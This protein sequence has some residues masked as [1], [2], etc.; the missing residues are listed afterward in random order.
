MAAGRL[1]RI[2]RPATRGARAGAVRVA[3]DA[4]AARDAPDGREGS[5]PTGIAWLRWTAAGPVGPAGSPAT[6]LSPVATPLFA[7]VLAGEHALTGFRNKNLQA[8]LYSTPPASPTEQRQRSARVTRSIAKLHGHGLIAKVKDGRLYRV[9]ER[10]ASLIAAA[11]LCRN[12]EFPEQV[13]QPA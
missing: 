7:A 10:G 11:I 1:A 12:K 5:P 8:R 2:A 13:L 3:G 6:G 9:T 4:P